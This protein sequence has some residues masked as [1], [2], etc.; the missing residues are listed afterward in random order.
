MP[1]YVY[2]CEADHET[3]V[4]CSIEARPDRL[5]CPDCGAPTQRKMCAPALHTLATF[6]SSIGDEV[7][8]RSRDPGDGSYFDPNL[9]FDRKT[10]K[11]TRIRSK[12]HREQL[13]KEAGLHERPPT[14]VTKDADSYK[15][16]KP[17][18]FS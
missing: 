5:V 17:L 13:M 18:Y 1:L 15:R 16:R 9:G 7:V 2:S 3:E 6:T 14:D 4:V 10:G 12:A 8:Q 11:H